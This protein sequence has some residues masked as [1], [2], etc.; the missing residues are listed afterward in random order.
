MIIGVDEVGRGCLAGPVCVAAVALG[1]PI[2]GL[3]DSKKIP[4]AKRERLSL[5]IKQTALYVGIGWAGPGEIDAFGLTGALRRAALRALHECDAQATEI[6]L[7]GHDNYI[8]DTRVRTIIKGDASEP[9]ISA[10][11]IVAKVAR[12]HYM[13]AIHATF[14]HY[15]FSSHVGYATKQHRDAIETHGPCNLHRFSFEPVRSAYGLSL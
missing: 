10:A 2:V 14:P 1:V 6:L 3:G 7:D 9:C 15:G 13:H 4:A 11:S 8:K 5:E 12:D